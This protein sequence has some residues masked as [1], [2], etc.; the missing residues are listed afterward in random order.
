MEA[1]VE[2]DAGQ[3]TITQNLDAV[4][5]LMGVPEDDRARF[6]FEMW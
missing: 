3:E 6:C 5:K 1:W 2:S 4:A